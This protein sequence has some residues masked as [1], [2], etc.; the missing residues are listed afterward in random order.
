MVVYFLEKS[1]QLID[2]NQ[3]TDLQIKDKAG[4]V[5]G[6]AAEGNTCNSSWHQQPLKPSQAKPSQ[7]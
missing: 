5:E 4:K 3:L 2:Q 1:I 7:A 6:F